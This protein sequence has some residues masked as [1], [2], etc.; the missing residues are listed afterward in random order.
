MPKQPNPR[1]EESSAMSSE[2]A[3]LGSCVLFTDA[4]TKGGPRIGGAI[5]RAQGRKKRLIEVKRFSRA[6][7]KTESIDHMEYEALIEGM[8][9]AKQLG[10]QWLWAFVDR[11]PI[12][13]QF[14]E[15]PRRPAVSSRKNLRTVVELS[16][17]F[18]SFGISWLPRDLN[19]ADAIARSTLQ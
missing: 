19:V 15:C 11:R 1:A 8:R 16:W 4:G 12:V 9:L 14:Y 18:T 3:K 10:V 5:F 6:A 2:V 13:Q 17:A 7:Q